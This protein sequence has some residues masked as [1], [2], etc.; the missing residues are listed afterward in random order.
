MNNQKIHTNIKIKTILAVVF[1]FC[2]IISSCAVKNSIKQFLNVDSASHY[3][4]TSSGKSNFY[5]VSA[6]LKCKFCKDR[7]IL[8][9]DH[10]LK[11]FSLA[12]AQEILTFTF[13]VIC[14]AFLLIKAPNHPF[15]NS[16]KIRGTLPIFLQ[17]R[18]LII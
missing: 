7:E 14:G 11:D 8:A 1:A 15:Y 10:N 18:K 12:D 13:L 9:K 6:A 3:Q 4:T 17:Y 5:S 2:I 16:S